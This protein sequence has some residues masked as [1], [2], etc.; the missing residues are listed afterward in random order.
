[1]D[2]KQKTVLITGASRGIGKAVALNFAK[3]GCRLALTCKKEEAQLNAV[4]KKA[5]RFGAPCRS[6]V[7]D[8]GSYESMRQVFE[9]IKSVFG[10]VDILIN[11]AGIAH[12][13]LFTDTTPDEWQHI[14]QTNLCSVLNCC[15]LAVSDMVRQKSGRIIN[16]SSV[17]GNA[18]A[19]CEAVYSASKGAVNSFTKA[20]AKELAP[21]G[22]CVNAIAC[23]AIDTDMNGFLTPGERR[24]LIDEIP[25]CRLGRPEEVA[26]L[27]ARLAGAPSYLTGQIITMDGAWL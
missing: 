12:V 4:V 18:G 19:S 6:Y 26:E 17:W 21:S 11:N 10:P 22:I 16:I 3:L 25:A 9:D 14:I 15:H 27:A 20:L 24:M 8:A 2:L 7:S 5:E 23:G 1:M 13:G